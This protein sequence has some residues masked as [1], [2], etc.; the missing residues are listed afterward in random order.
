M[1]KGATE[2]VEAAWGQRRYSANNR[3]RPTAHDAKKFSK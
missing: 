2:Q 3:E 1:Q